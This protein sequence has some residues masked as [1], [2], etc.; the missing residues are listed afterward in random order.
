MSHSLF[1]ILYSAN[2]T[3][4]TIGFILN[5]SKS[6][7]YSRYV[8]WP[9]NTQWLDFL[10]ISHNLSYVIMVDVVNLRGKSGPLLSQAHNYASHT[11]INAALIILLN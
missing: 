2:N 3:T 1:V 5:D 6:S 8:H 7:N 4:F 9:T 10:S 11:K